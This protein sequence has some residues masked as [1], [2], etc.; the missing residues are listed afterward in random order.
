MKII[1]WAKFKMRSGYEPP[2]DEFTRR[3]R[4]LCVLLSLPT[5]IFIHLAY[6]RSVKAATELWDVSST[7]EQH[8]AVTT[9]VGIVSKGYRKKAA[10]M[11]RHLDRP[12]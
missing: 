6:R 12:L 7:K 5:P 11:A 8:D 1:Q 2:E 4:R 3:L 9:L 10:R